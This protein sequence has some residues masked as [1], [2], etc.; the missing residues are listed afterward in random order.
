MLTFAGCRREERRN[1]D[2]LAILP[3]ENLTGDRSLDWIGPAISGALAY[4][5]SASIRT[6]P[7]RAGARNDALAGRAT[8]ILQGYYT[9]SGDRVVYHAVIQNVAS[10]Q[11]E[12]ALDATSSLNQGLAE[13]AGAMAKAM[14]KRVRSFPTNNAG[15]LKAWGEAQLASAPADREAA[16]QRAIKADANFG[17]AYVELA[18]TQIQRGDAAAAS[19]TIA[20]AKQRLAMLSDLAQA[21]LELL[22]A[23]L[24]NRLDQRRTALREL[25][26]LTSTDPSTVI[27]LAELEFNR[28]DFDAAVELYKNALALEPDNAEV[29]NQ[30]G[31]AEAYAGRLDEARA[32]L[33]RYREA[34]PNQ[35]N[36]FDSLGE[37][38]FFHGRFNDAEK[39]FLEAQ[40]IDP[41]FLGGA[42]LLKAAQAR[43][44]AGDLAGADALHQQFIDSRRRANDPLAAVENSQWLFITGRRRQAMDALASL[45]GAA[46]GD[47]RAYAEAQLAIWKVQTGD[48]SEA[49]R[50]AHAAVQ[51][52]ASPRVAGL[53]AIC[54]A[55]VG[56]GAP[57][58]LPAQ[59][60]Q[61]AE[62]YRL[63]FARD[64]QAASQ[65][66]RELYARSTPGSDGDVRT[67]YA[68]SLVETGRA[69]EAAPLVQ[70]YPIPLNPRS[71][72]VFTSVMFPRFLAVRGAALKSEADIQLFRKCGG[73][74][75]D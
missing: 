20:S 3:F 26:R 14:D 27:A 18:Q 47:L 24:S 44:L 41:K 52:A 50:L 66:L 56:A 28:R 60:Q 38:H 29:M 22:D 49:Q 42:E 58:Q 65:R 74:A 2:R 25:T 17:L 36:P 35:A 68:W 6:Y 70:L 8:K 34:A 4:D 1:V 16:L 12:Q 30:L 63:V 19:A 10:V 53:A 55:A 61:A 9:R 69:S 57:S 11:D 72:L 46:R 21:R 45:A 15:A 33:E 59:A 37:V 67:L 23:T 64:F 31:Y 43:L 73:G 71:D 48:R 51:D 75:Q 13:A 32:V 40:R 7:F 62:T 54:S 5:L 39:Y